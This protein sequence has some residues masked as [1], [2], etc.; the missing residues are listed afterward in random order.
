MQTMLSKVKQF[1]LLVFFLFGLTYCFSCDET[2]TVVNGVVNNGNGTYTVTLTACMEPDDFTGSTSYFFA[3]FGGANVISAAPNS[4]TYSDGTVHTLN[5]IPGNNGNVMWSG[6]TVGLGESQNCFTFAVTLNGLPT[7]LDTENGHSGCSHSATFPTTVNLTCA[8]INFA[9][10]GGTSSNYG[11]NQNTITTICPDNPGGIVTVTFSGIV[12]TD[13]SFGDCVDALSIYQG[14]NTTGALIGTFCEYDASPGAVTSTD[15]SG[16]LTFQFVSDGSTTRSGW[17]S[18]IS[19]FYPCAAEATISGTASICEGE[20]TTISVSLNGTAPWSLTYT[21]GTTPVMVNGINASPYTFNV[22]PTTSKTYTITSVSDAS[23]VGTANGSATVTVASAPDPTYTD[24]STNPTCV[25]PNTGSITINPTSVNTTFDWVSG[26]ITSPIPV[27]NL[28]GGATDER[29]LVNLPAGTYCVDITR[30]TTSTTNTVIFTETF[31]DGGTNWTLNNSNGT[32]IWDV[33][34]SFAGGTC[35]GIGS[36]AATPNQPAAVTGSPQSNYLHIRATSTS[37]VTC[38]AG[39]VNFPPLAAN[40]NGSQASNQ[41]AT[42]N[43]AIVTTGMSN[44]SVSFYWLGDGD[45]NDFAVLEY[46]TNGGAAWTQAGGILNNQP[47]WTTA[48]RTDPI[49]ANQADLR[50]RFRWVNNSSSSQD[51]PIAIDQIVITADVT[52][53]CDK[54]IQECYTLTNPA[55]IVPTFNPLTAVCQNAAAPVLPSPSTNGISGTWAPAVSTA[56]SGTTVYTFTPNA[57]QC[58]T[59][60][61]LNLTVNP[62]VAPA[63]TCGIL[64]TTSVQFNWTALTGATNYAITYTVNGGAVQNGGN[65]AATTY[66]VNSLS[67]GDVVVISVTPTGTGCFQA[68][69]G[70]CTANDCTPPVIDVQPPADITICEGLPVNIDVTVTGGTGFQ[71]QISTNG[72]ASYTNLSNGGI[73][74]NVTTSSLDI[75]DATGLDG[76]IYQLVVTAADPAC[77]TLSNPATNLHVNAKVDPTFTQIPS[78]CENGV[79]PAFATNSNNGVLGSWNPAII[80]VTPSGTTTYTFTPNAGECANT[81]TMDITVNPILTPSINCGVSTTSSVS[82][83]WNDVLGASSYNIDYTINSGVVQ[84]TSNATSDFSLL[85]LSINDIVDVTVTPIGTG[86]FAAGTGQCQA[87]DCVPPVINAQP[88][89]DVNCIGTSVNL[90]V[91]QTGGTGYQWQI[92][93]DN[94]TT[95][96]NLSASAVYSGVNTSTLIINDN[97]GLHGN[98]YRVIVTEANNTCPISSSAAVLTVN[99]FSSPVINCGTLSTSSVTFDWAALSGATSY[100]ITYRINGGVVQ[101]GGN[102]TNPTYTVSGLN[103]N[104]IVEITVTPNGTGCFTD[105]TGTCTAINCTPPTINSQPQDITLCEGNTHTFSVTEVGG[106]NYQWQESTDGGVTFTPL[107]DGGVYSGTTTIGLTISDVTGLSGNQYRVVVNEVNG[108]CPTTSS[109]ATLIVN[110]ILSA[111]IT[112]GTSTVSSVQFDWSAV[113]GATDYDI[114]YSINGGT[115]QSGGNQTSTGFSVTGLNPND[116]VDI[117]ITTNG[118]GCYIDGVGQ[119]TAIDCITPTIN[120]EPQDNSS[121]TGS[122]LVLSVNETGGNAYQWQISTD[123]GATF[124]NLIDGGVYSGSTT[125]ALSI[126]DNTGLNGA[127]YRLII[128]EVNNTCPATSAVAILTELSVET[129]VITCG[130]ATISSV[131][132]DWTAL[133]G[134][135]DYDISYSIN[136]GTAQSGGNQATTTFILN[137]L[138]QNDLVDIVVT[139][140]GTQCYLVGNANCQALDCIEP[141]ITNQ[142]QN[143]SGC[144]GT[145][146]GF[147]INQTGGTN[148]QWQISLDGGVSFVNLTNVGVFSGVTTNVLSISDNTGLN[149]A[150]FRCVVSE[151][152]G[153]CPTTSSNAT[154]TVF[155]LP[156]IAASNNG[157]LCEGQ[158]LDLTVTTVAGASYSWSGPAFASLSQNPTIPSTVPANGGDY[159]VIVTLNGCTSSSTTTVVI[160]SPTVVNINPAGPFCANDGSVFLT[161]DVP[162]GVWSGNGITDANTGAFDPAQAAVGQ[163]NITYTIVGGC[164]GSASSSIVIFGTPDADFTVD[165]IVLDPINPLVVTHNQ[166]QDAINYH[167]EFGDGNTSTSFEPT[168]L[169]PLDVRSYTITLIAESFEGC[170]DTSTLIVTVPETL[171]FYVPNTFTPNGDEMNNYFTP[172]FTSGY[173]PQDYQLLVYNRWGELIFESLDAAVGWD[174]TYKN[175]GLVQVGT[176]TWKIIFGLSMNS[177]KK[178]IVGHVNVLK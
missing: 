154:L 14:V 21:D 95:F 109:N 171:I 163:N 33:N 139:A 28:P 24:G 44:I 156:I 58:A 115:V 167:W 143:R 138:T 131:Q 71:W 49:W 70:T 52:S 103:A 4:I 85:G 169:Y 140:N 118:T 161:A 5:A 148:V 50:F 145:S 80:S 155:P 172:I 122:A 162:G 3:S 20:S 29:A 40:F 90:T 102:T 7:S 32:N 119:C 178:T 153:S 114:A 15:P 56:S 123:N 72:G 64:S 75:S 10:S 6:P 89:D 132:F 164:G 48:T 92:S 8:S 45:A 30:T 117:T 104:D 124:A 13:G 159:T 53:T 23:C 54:T 128:S 110:P 31:E 47:S 126:S 22:S 51:P 39:S 134:A 68:G 84:N 61:I 12:N 160:N 19:C 101:I 129:P 173:D 83:D 79:A 38:G 177:E 165:H 66:S 120:T 77:P 136:G 151:V 100:D 146:V 141:T 112:C 76:N 2:S 99:A 74:S 135:T 87:L 157:P 43:N 60:A 93:T 67:P 18:T 42:L 36:V 149:G 96:T 108:L 88:Q 17:S 91:N 65:I 16:C 35:A 113:S 116:I 152:N 37:P 176:Y 86:C 107:T 97:T 46:S 62:L 111:V 144:E 25:G 150:I 27:G 125:T 98:Q 158:Q 26:P 1:S 147:S 130:T 106:T 142:P 174:G 63:I 168:N 73:Y 82:F 127:Q 133:T 105:A 175:G 121:C 9:D 34:N 11:N 170:R 166:S 94:G 69:T 57:G 81:T 59:T 55:T 137:G 78:F 41:T